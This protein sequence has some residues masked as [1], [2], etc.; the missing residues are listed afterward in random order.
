MALAGHFSLW[1][2]EDVLDGGD[3][4]N[5][6]FL[7][8]RLKKCVAVDSKKPLERTCKHA[9]DAA[10]NNDPRV[11]RTAK[12][13]FSSKLSDSK[14]FQISL[15]PLRLEPRSCRFARVFGAE[16]FLYLA[17][18][19]LNKPP[20]VF[21]GMAE[22][23]PT[24][25]QQW[26]N[27]MDKEF[28]GCSWSVIFV[29]PIK[30]KKKADAGNIEEASSYQVILFATEGPGLEKTSIDEILN[31]FMPVHLNMGLSS[32]KAF[33]HIELGF[34]KTFPTLLFQ[35]DQVRQV[36]DIYANGASEGIAYNDPD[37][38]WRTHHDQTK[39]RVMNDGCSRISFQAAK[40]V[41][42]FLGNDGIVPSAF[43]ARIG[44][45]KGVWMS[46]P[47]PQGRDLD[48]DD[49]WIE[50]TES[51]RKFLPHVVDRSNNTFDHNRLTFEVLNWAR[52][53][54]PSILY[55][56]YLPILEDRKVTRDSMIAFVQ[57]AME[58][59]ESSLML[60]LE[61]DIVLYKYVQDRW[62]DFEVDFNSENPQARTLSAKVK[63]MLEV[64]LLGG[65]TTVRV[66]IG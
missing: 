14:A 40:R 19:R 34:S 15:S 47:P 24:R 66:L 49:V 42:Q 33:A 29:R 9:W 37:M 27:T 50:V 21:R 53:P 7:W 2:L 12:L 36:E 28:L 1:D 55:R 48:G 38:D 61:D 45:W 22:V 56:D 59:E 39:P 5:Y 35:P 18:P 54:S 43:Q 30:S 41:W 51:Q 65:R 11:T 52:R 32:C 25:F 6:N 62:F 31:W 4:S 23:L 13:I 46:E 20:T 64:S 3:C 26:L 63:M 16:R 57:K 8:E 10:I 44:P 60:A 58:A 17:V